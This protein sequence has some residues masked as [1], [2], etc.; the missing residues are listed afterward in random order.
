MNLFNFP[1]RRPVTII[2]AMFIALILGGISLWKTPLDL[3]P[4][5]TFPNLMA[6]IEYE[7]A[8]PEEIER[9]VA[10]PLEAVIKTVPNVKNVYSTSGEGNCILNVEFNW[11]T[12]LD[13]ASA[14]LREKMGMVKKYLPDGVEDPVIMRINF[15]EMP[16]LF[17]NLSGEGR[18][19]SELNKIG[20]DQVAPALERISGVASVTVLGGRQREIQVNLDKKKLVAYGLGI[21][22]V[23]NAIR[24]QNLNLTAGHFEQS[25]MRFR[26]KAE[27]EFTNLEDLRNLVVG[28]GMTAAQ[29]Q[30]QQLQAMTGLAAP[31]A[32]QGA[33]SPIRLR[34]IAEVKD[35]FKEFLGA[36]RVIDKNGAHAGVGMAVMKET[37]ANTVIVARK[38]K[39][40]LP[41][42]QKALPRGT[43]LDI[44]FDISQ[45][46]ED[47]I[48]ALRSSA[49]E[50]GIYAIIVILVFLWQIV[51]TLI[52]AL[53]IP[54]SLLIALVCMYFSGYTLNIM[55]LG[56]MVIA[57]GK[58]VDDSIVVVENI[59]RHLGMGKNPHQAA[60]DA[61][62]EV[63]VAV[64]AATL[65]AVIVFLPIAFTQGLSAQLFSSFAATIFYALMASLLVSFTVAPMLGS[66]LLRPRAAE[67]AG[68]KSH[69]KVW[70]RVQD[71]YGKLLGW[72]LDHK[73]K[74]LI[75]ATLILVIT[76]MMASMIPTEFVPNFVGG[77]YEARM[78]LPVGSSIEETKKLVNRVE[79]KMS[80]FKDVDKMFM[81]IGQTGDPKRAAF[82]GQEQ[83]TH[84]STLMIKFPKKVEG[85]VTTD[86]QL[87]QAWDELG[88]ELPG[89]KV[90][91][92]AAGGLQFQSTKPI[93]I[94]IFGDDFA[95]LKKISDQIAGKVKKV[96]GVKDVTTTMEE[97]TPELVYALDRTRLS[98]YGMVTGQAALALQTGVD[99][100]VASIYRESGDEFDIRV[101]LRETDRNSPKE[102]SSAPLS[103]PLGFSLPIRDVSHP[104][105]TQGP[106]NIKRENSKRVV[107]VE[108]NKTDRALGLIVA[109][110]EK[111]LPGVVVPEGYFMDFGGE[112]KDQMDAFEDLAIMFGLGVILIY[113]VIA[114]LYESL[115]H[116]FTIMVPAA[117]FSF[118]GAVIGL[119]LTH[120]GF[121]VTAFIGI[122]MLIGIVATNSIVFVDFILE[123]HRQGMDRRQA[124][125]EAGRTRLRPILMT[126]LTTLFGVLPIAMGRAEGMEMQQP[127]G[128]VVVGGLC[129]ST[130]LTLIVI[131]AVYEVMDQLALDIKNLFRRKKA[132]PAPAPS[133]T[134]GGGGAG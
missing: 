59:Y 122:I 51:P 104:Y 38:V 114:S 15:K 134:P 105:F 58:L 37:D 71:Q 13:S 50:G 34:D 111:I 70:G 57:V 75:L 116:P 21:T 131:P 4:D 41:Q 81:M 91:L 46:V 99:G 49:V 101:Q 100:E 20:T 62:R 96:E 1:V 94:K 39:A 121:G 27:G 26:V 7:G 97:G 14:D 60:E 112:R 129:S 98:N 80:R 10:R 6:I 128:I 120:T 36:V 53:S 47:A 52:V 18:H 107:T 11:G 87:R 86:A 45:F 29:R 54:L 16:I 30:Q 67:Q 56:A 103:S 73:G 83:G 79:Q 23:V 109:D 3:M 124:I 84:Q 66:R 25:G 102:I 2:M 5:I 78:D 90:A 61:T 126:A 74:V 77:I 125:I 40:I 9:T 106:V 17:L 115:V 117:L 123:Y 130:F 32:G 33:V 28:N 44:S 108:A 35:D 118:T 113:M 31:L 68:D 89:A 85:R 8:G 24:Y 133:P 93:A 110:I 92:R 22:D 55:T 82:T 48:G 42:V 64:T 132:P 95:V 88:R 76:G 127:L 63:S 69:L 65:V 12:N 72:T 19:L 43:N 119:Y